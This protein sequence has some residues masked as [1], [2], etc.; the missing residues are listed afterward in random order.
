MNKM[1]QV[2]KIKIEAIKK[3]QTEATMEIENLGKSPGMTDA[4][5]TN[6]I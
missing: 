4:S 3:M 2:L 5:I 6:R 1:V